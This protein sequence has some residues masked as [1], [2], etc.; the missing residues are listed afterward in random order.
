MKEALIRKKAVEILAKK[1]F[2]YWYPA[3]VRFK[4]NDIFGVF[5]L[6]C[7][8]KKSANIKFV[9][10]TTCSNLSARRKKIQFF[11]KE[12]KIPAKISVGVEIWGWSQKK[13]EFKIEEV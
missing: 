6:V 10:L 11:M 12:N 3:K 5:D 13:R 2:V 1:G 7:W 4:Q 9:Q 8:R